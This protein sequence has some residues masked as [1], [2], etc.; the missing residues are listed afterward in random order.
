MHATKDAETFEHESGAASLPKFGIFRFRVRCYNK[1]GMRSRLH[2]L[3]CIALGLVLASPLRAVVVGTGI[4]NGDA[5]AAIIDG[6]PAIAW[7]AG[8][9]SSPVKVICTRGGCPRLVMGRTGHR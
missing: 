7:V 5:D 4:P 8:K 6:H 2:F 3:L 9:G 1:S